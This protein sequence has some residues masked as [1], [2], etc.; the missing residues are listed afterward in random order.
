MPSKDNLKGTSVPWLL[1][2]PGKARSVVEHPQIRTAGSKGDM[3]VSRIVPTMV[4]VLR[5]IS[6]DTRIE[7][8][9][10]YACANI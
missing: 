2:G 3:K 10:A 8:M 1:T 9:N 7:R 4:F 6:W 5:P